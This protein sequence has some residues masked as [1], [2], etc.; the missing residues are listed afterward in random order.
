METQ[1]TGGELE[2]PVQMSWWLH[3]EEPCGPA[4]VLLMARPVLDLSFPKD[5]GF[6]GQLCHL[7]GHLSPPQECYDVPWVPPGTALQCRQ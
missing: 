5:A 1:L 6:S 7:E 2:D 4:E 3:H